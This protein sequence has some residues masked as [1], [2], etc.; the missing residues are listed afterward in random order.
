MF[1][2]TRSAVNQGA[3]RIF[4]LSM[5][6]S[7]AKR[8]NRPKILLVTW[9]AGMF[10]LLGFSVLIFT[11]GKIP[12]KGG[13]SSSTGASVLFAT[14]FLWFICALSLL[15]ASSK[16]AGADKLRISPN[17]VELW[18]G[19]RLAGSW[20]WDT[21]SDHFILTDCSKS[22]SAGA[23]GNPMYFINNSRFLSRDNSLTKEA[24]E[25]VLVAAERNGVN[26]AWRPGSPMQYNYPVTIYE[27]VGRARAS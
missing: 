25:A 8:M 3:E 6:R 14:V 15:V 17:G 11:I 26:V 19:S 22:P 2:E 1:E 27:V 16:L 24:F 4:D 12:G 13:W 9:I 10:A 23:G 18:S 20:R 5:V 21:P 7:A